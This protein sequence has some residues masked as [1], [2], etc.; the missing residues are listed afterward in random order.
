MKIVAKLTLG[1]LCAG[2][3]QAAS[4]PCPE[5]EAQREV[6]RGMREIYSRQKTDYVELLEKKSGYDADTIRIRKGEAERIDK[7]IKE[8]IEKK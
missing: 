6:A 3:L 4:C 2:L 1:V 5:A 7:A 8:I